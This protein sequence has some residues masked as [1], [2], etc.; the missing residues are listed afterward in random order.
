MSLATQF[1]LT[2]KTAIVTGAAGLLGR[3]H[4]RALAEAGA[5][6]VATDISQTACEAVAAE[7]GGKAIGISANVTDPESLRALADAV[8][9]RTGRI[10]VLV[11]N[12]AINDM[13]ENPATV[14]ESSRFENYP[15]ELWKR[16]LEVNVT[17]VFLCSQIIGAEMAKAGQGSIINIGSTYGVV[18][19]DQSLY[20]DEAGRQQFYKSAV[21]PTTKG[22]VLAFTRFLAAYWGEAGV[23]VNALSPGG[24]ENQQNAYFISEYARRTPMKRMAS[25]T[26]FM[27]ALVF[28]ASDASAYVTGANLPVD[29]G[30]TIW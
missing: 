12:A 26:D 9:A 27:G 10:D 15:L 8:L 22:A 18:A 19:P 3:R 28:L 29:G 4:C 1:D 6:V 11:N 30:F 2:G 16:S 5:T 20:R 7:L 21:Y 14:L 13:V 17:G 24:V 25:P 23:R